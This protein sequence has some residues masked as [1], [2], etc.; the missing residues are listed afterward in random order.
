MGRTAYRTHHAIE[1]TEAL[2]GSTVTLAGWVD[3]R[4]DHGGVAFI[5]LRDST[6]LVQVVINDEEIARPLRSEFVVQVV[7]K[8]RERPEGNENVHLA[9][10]KVEVVVR[11]LTVLA[12]SEALPFQVSTALENESENKLPGEDVRLKYR[13]L[14]LRRPQM[15]K[16][17]KLRSD[18]T[19]AARHALEDMDFT[20]V[21]TPTFIKSTPEG[22]RDFVVPARLVPGSW[23]ALPQSPQ[24]LKQLLMVGGVERY[25][26]LARCYRDEDFRADRQ[27]EFTQLDIE[28]S[29]VS[30]ED[31]M[32][33]A[34]KVIAAIWKTR[35]YVVTLPLP[36]I[37]WR[38]AMDKYGS[39][40]PDLRFG[41]PI[42]ELTEY[43][44]DTPFRVFQA[45]YV[46]AI[47]FKNGSSTPRRQF[48]AWQE[49]AKQRG[50]KGLAYV[51]FTADGELKGPVAKNLSDQERNGLK[52]AVGA[53]DGDAVFFAAG[54][55]ESSQ[56]L[57]GA[58]RVELARR[59]GML[60]P[61]EFAFT[62]VVD[63]PLF[64][65]TDDPDDDDVAVGHSKWTSMHHPFTMPSADWI[66]RFDKDPGHAMSDSYDI[67]C[68]GEEMGGGSVRIHR[69]DI[70]D[71][72][73]NVLGIEPE[74]AKEKFGFL[75]EA[76]KYGA[77]PHAGIAL[78]WDRTVSIL[79]GTDSIRDVIAFPKA[80]GGRDP[81]TGAP[82]PISDAQRAE[83]GV[84][85]DPD[86]D[87]D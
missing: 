77:P 58:V 31:V 42:V 4:R 11:E 2:I 26:Q 50:A 17:L 72:V 66:D 68:N 81:L 54:S 46:G 84:D 52:S 79:A 5:D 80:G 36:R 45:P 37:S 48:D 40:K 49:W 75:L 16:S 33:M 71:R 22:A 82:A 39:D 64:K 10:G 12:K 41:N 76:F 6:G 27:P 87:K 30:Q 14:D 69:D 35:G 38:D 25:Y 57:L 9:T 32:A 73:L 53:E 20:E 29:Y 23:Y 86:E 34:E 44:K 56:L 43:F 15:Q 60:H 1:V 7:G 19:R 70:Q 65:R 85:Y 24:L 51:Q 74:E 13:Y 18:M 21:E 62:W 3:R 55:R 28:M 8:V 78:G 59:A 47:V 63:F 83:T 61:D 67:V